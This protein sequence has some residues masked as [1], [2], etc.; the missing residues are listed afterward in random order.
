MEKNIIWRVTTL[1]IYHRMGER[2]GLFRTKGRW[3]EGKNSLQ[4]KVYC[5]FWW[6]VLS[7]GRHGCIIW[8]GGDVSYNPYIHFERIYDRD[9]TECRLGMILFTWII[10]KL[11]CYVTFCSACL[12]IIVS[13]DISHMRRKMISWRW[14]VC[15]VT[16]TSDFS[17]NI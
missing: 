14:G 3:P 12:I 4:M 10:F 1:F 2:G 17:D 7:L 15:D 5:L 11:D 16:M 13:N 6:G 8:G 9:T